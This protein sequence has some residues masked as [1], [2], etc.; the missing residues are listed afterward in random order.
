MSFIYS[1]NRQ[2]KVD[3]TSLI[4]DCQIFNSQFEC[5]ELRSLKDYIQ[6]ISTN[7]CDV[8]LILNFL[9]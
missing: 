2:Y 4:K 9:K 7:Y 3:I 1:K 6:S 8:I 5:N